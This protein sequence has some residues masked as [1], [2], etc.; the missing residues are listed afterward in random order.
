MEMDIRDGDGHMVR[1]GDRY[2]LGQRVQTRGGG[3]DWL[4]MG[5]RL[6]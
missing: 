4:G 5:L 3:V 6:R 2:I 1:A